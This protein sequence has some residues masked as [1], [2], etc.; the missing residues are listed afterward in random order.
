MLRRVR[1]RP[2][3]EINIVPYIDVMLVLLV[4]F[5]IAAPLL[6]MG[7]NVQLP[8]A[9]AELLESEHREPLIASVDA[10]G[11]MYLNVGDNPDAPVEAETLVQRAAAVLRNQPGTPV[12]VRG[13]AT[14]DYG[15]VVTVMTLL[16][17]AGAPSVGLMT[18]P[19]EPAARR[20]R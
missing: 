12:M 7:V 2:M 5:M 9:Q 20:S 4:V 1:K 3:S 18:E 13:D 17:R 14:A 8:Q 15:S 6:T 19:L 11:R 16:Q 10:G